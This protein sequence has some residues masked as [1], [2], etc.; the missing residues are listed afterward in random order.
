M[1]LKYARPLNYARIG[2]FERLMERS[3]EEVR[4]TVRF[5]KH[6]LFIEITGSRFREVNL[7]VFGLCLYLDH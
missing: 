7:S 4:I 5:S 1:Q 2:V 3:R 6:C